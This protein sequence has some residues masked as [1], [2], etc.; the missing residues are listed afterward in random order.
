VF[1]ACVLVALWRRL[2]RHWQRRPG[3]TAQI[4]FRRYLGPDRTK[5][6]IF[7]AN[8]DGSGERRL[9]SAPGET[10][11]DYPD[12]AP[13][14]SFVAFQRC[15]RHTCGIY[16]INTD[17]NGLRRV[18]D[19][20][21]RRPPKCT[22]NSYPAI[23]PDGRQIAFVRAF[24]RIRHDQIDHA[25]IYRMRIDGSHIRKVS[26]PATRTAED[27][28]PQWSPDGKQ[29][30][31]V[32]HNVSAKPKGQ[33]A[34]FVINADG[35]GRRRVT[36]YNIKAGDG[37]DWS[38]DGSQILFRS[39]EN[40]DFLDS[41]IW[42]IHPDGTG[43]RQV[44]HA[45]P[46]TKVYSASF[47]PD[48]TAITLGMS[49]VDGQADVW[50]IGSMARGSR[51]SPE[52]RCG[53]ARRTGA[54]RDN[55]RRRNTVQRAA[56]GPTPLSSGATRRDSELDDLQSKG[57]LTRQ[58]GAGRRSRGGRDGQKDAGHRSRDDRAV[59][60][61]LRRLQRR[62]LRPGDTSPG[63]GGRSDRGSGAQQRDAG[64]RGAH[65]GHRSLGRR[66]RSLGRRAAEACVRG[67]RATTRRIRSGNGPLRCGAGRPSEG[68]AV[69]VQPA[70]VAGP[71]REDAVILAAT[72]VCRPGHA[73]K[74]DPPD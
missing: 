44:T 35:T 25:G 4:A 67:G 3:L 61:R 55:A 52:P 46:T 23:S 12:M 19:G 53:T 49:G 40:E 2:P 21:R 62:C 20:C 15:G 6:A 69:R 5:G 29:I 1:V 33:Q 9:A 27:G 64:G 47:S 68:D 70:G 54:E 73:C 63:R 30:V 32:R 11:D 50:T 16:V 13:D 34:V 72:P 56:R 39:P 45:G 59:C 74:F 24:G 65:G 7:V 48:G 38:P 31:F 8:R 58:A 37:P 18:D 10:S 66:A 42:T 43:L 41:D 17:G 14:G 36:P 57:G 26:L 51:Q 22:D 71:D 28:D 60:G